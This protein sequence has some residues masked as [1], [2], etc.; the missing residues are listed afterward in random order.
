MAYVKRLFLLLLIIS[1]TA[2]A[3]VERMEHA[4]L[5]E[6]YLNQ[7]SDYRTGIFIVD[8]S[9]RAVS[10]AMR[11]VLLNEQQVEYNGTYTVVKEKINAIKEKIEPVETFKQ[12]KKPK[13]SVPDSDIIYKKQ[14]QYFKELQD[15]LLSPG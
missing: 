7:P 1:N 11:K 14:E 6:Y 4:N 5:L 2:T 8:P 12:K 9:L 15:F 3:K 13:V 10:D